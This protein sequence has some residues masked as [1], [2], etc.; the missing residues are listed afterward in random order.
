M[1]A[2]QGGNLAITCLCPPAAFETRGTGTTG[3]GDG[4]LE[5]VLDRLLNFAFSLVEGVLGVR[6]AGTASSYQ[7]GTAA[8]GEGAK[9]SLFHTLGENFS[10]A[11][12]AVLGK[13]L[14]GV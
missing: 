6:A 13:I 1:R 8:A 14:G 12:P 11:A 7:S 4:L 3:L 10:T 2:A 9:K 5:R